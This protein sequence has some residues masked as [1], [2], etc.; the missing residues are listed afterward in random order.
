MQ[1]EPLAVWGPGFSVMLVFDVYEDLGKTIFGIR[2]LE[3]RINLPP[4]AWL[5]TVRQVLSDLERKAIEADCHE[6]RLAGRDWSRVLEGM[7]W[8]PMEGLLQGKNGLRKALA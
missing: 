2:Y 1:L 5:A 3:G 7:G 4:K 6:M 8:E